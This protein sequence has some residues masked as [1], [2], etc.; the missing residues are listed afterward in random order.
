MGP[1]P[2]R[3]LVGGRVELRQ[4]YQRQF[5]QEAFVAAGAVVEV[6]GVG[7]LDGAVEEG[8]GATPG[9]LAVAVADGGAHLQQGQGGGVAADQKVAE[10]LGKAGDE[11]VAVEA[12]VQHLVE[13]QEGVARL[14][15]QQLVRQAEVV[16]IVQDVEVLYHALVGD[17]PAGEA[18]HLVE[19]GQGVAHP[20]VGLEGNDVEGFRLGRD[21][22]FGGDVG[23]VCHDVLH[24]DA[25]EVVYLATGED[26]GQNLVLLRRGKDEDGVARRL[27]QRLEEGVKGRGGEHVHLVDD[28]DLVAAYLGRDA[29]LLHQLPDVVHR[30]VGG[31]VQLVDVV[32]ALFVEGDARLAFVARF[33][34]R[35]GMQAVDGLGEDAGARG[36]AHATRTAE[37]VGVGQL[38]RGDGVLQRGGQGVLSHHRFE[39]G[40]AVF[41]GGYDIVFHMR[42]FKSVGQVCASFE[43]NDGS[44]AYFSGADYADCAD[45]L[46]CKSVDSMDH[47]NNKSVK[48][49]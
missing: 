39:G 18:D 32:R 37:E 43:S 40:R 8:D 34:V 49:A 12:L 23:Q 2:P 27:F 30:V 41:P 45:N 7:Q 28:V 33:A 46:R 5:H 13:K 10:V 14:P 36:L 44:S 1:K 9:L 21:S 4:F 48:S 16:F 26:G 25:L 29:H 38:A 3:R 19:D 6:A 31:G 35:R 11:V 20:A 15:G 22:L 42:L 17:A 47:A 24:A